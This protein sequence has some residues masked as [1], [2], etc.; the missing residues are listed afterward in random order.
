MRK[1]RGKTK[2]LWIT[3]NMSALKKATC[4]KNSEA[5]QITIKNVDNLGGF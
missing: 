1:R 4:A 2:K 3:I 5:V